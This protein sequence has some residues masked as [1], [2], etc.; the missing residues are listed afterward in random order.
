MEVTWRAG[1][2][3]PVGRGDLIMSKPENRWKRWTEEED[4]ILVGL[5]HNGYSLEDI[6]IITKRTQKAVRVR[7]NQKGLFIRYRGKEGKK[8]PVVKAKRIVK[9]DSFW[10]RCLQV[11]GG[12]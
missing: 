9:R 2:S 8:T 6:G 3:C 5:Y 12:L 11:F 10:K 7:L 1:W 4:E